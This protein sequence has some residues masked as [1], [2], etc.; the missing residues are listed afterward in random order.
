MAYEL[1]DNKATKFDSP[2]LTIRN[3]RIAFNADAGDILASAGIKLV[4]ILWDS[5]AC[6]VGLRPIAKQE[7]SAFKVSIPQGRRGGTIRAQS[8]LNYIQWRAT[9][10][11]TVDVHW[12]KAEQLL[13]ASLPREHVGT[14]EKG[15]D[16]GK[17]TERRPRRTAI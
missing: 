1:F 14:A 5:G 17:E 9:R 7:G 2:K 3:G 15:S 12:N 10:P 4:H 11:V 8:F 13:E 16:A 6:K